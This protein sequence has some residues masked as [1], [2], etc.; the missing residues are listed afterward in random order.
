MP[1]LAVTMANCRFVALTIVLVIVLAS[2][3][4][5]DASTSQTSGD[6]PEQ[7]V[8]E[9][10]DGAVVRFTDGAFKNTGSSTIR[11]ERNK[12]ITMQLTV[13]YSD[14]DPKKMPLLI[15]RLVSE[16]NRRGENTVLASGTATELQRESGSLTFDTWLVQDSR[17]TNAWIEVTEVLGKHEEVVLA[18]IGGFESK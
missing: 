6:A 15:I 16:K 8:V 10:P 5:D 2:A 1:I 11:L 7:L 13:P 3:G 4:C 12:S 9:S 17:F 14:A 18:T